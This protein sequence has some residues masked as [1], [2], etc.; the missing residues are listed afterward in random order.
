MNRVKSDR[1]EYAMSTFFNFF[2]LGIGIGAILLGSLAAATNYSS[3]YMVSILLFIFYWILYQIFGKNQ[4][5]VK[6]R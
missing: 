3:M 5:A 2:D 1:R 4:G 6:S